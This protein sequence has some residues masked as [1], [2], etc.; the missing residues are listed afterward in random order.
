MISNQ[1]QK[2]LAILTILLLI[3][4]LVVPI[5]SN[6]EGNTS[7]EFENPAG[8]G[9]EILV[10]TV[11]T[12]TVNVNFANPVEGAIALAGIVKFDS[13][14]L[15]LTNKVYDADGS[16]ILTGYNSLG[17]YVS[18]VEWNEIENPTDV[19]FAFRQSYGKLSEGLAFPLTFKVKDGATGTF[20]IEFSNV[21]YSDAAEVETTYPIQ[22]G[23]KVTVRIKV[24]LES[25]SLNKTQTTIY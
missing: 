2:V 21:Q 11:E 20:D 15:E 1:K 16:Y 7:I 24:P 4:N 9:K 23:E 25:I 5:V 12:F 10:G 13:T 6:A 14:K 19:T 18:A 3:F 8:E 17:N 22:I